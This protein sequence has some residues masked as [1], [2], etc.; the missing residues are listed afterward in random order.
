MEVTEAGF[1]HIFG[2]RHRTANAFVFT[3]DGKLFLQRRVHNKAEAKT[4][5]IAG[6]HVVHGMTYAEAAGEELL[7]ELKLYQIEEKLEG[8]LILIGQ[9]GQFRNDDAKSPN[10]EF[11]SLYTY[12]LTE[13]EWAHV[14]N[15]KNEIDVERAKRTETE[16]EKW[17]EEEQKK[18]EDGLGEV[19]GYHVVELSEVINSEN[20]HV[21]EKYSDGLKKQ[22]VGFSKDL[23]LPLANGIAPIR[24]VPKRLIRCRR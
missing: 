6:G 9:E 15:M 14:K 8:K 22:D 4:F 20:V 18:P 7:Q 10:N 19:W 13:K 17:I 21:T 3:P 12:V 2:L 16:F 5:S 1:T 11:R 24:M 23:L